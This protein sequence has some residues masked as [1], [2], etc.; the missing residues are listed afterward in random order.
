MWEVQ[1]RIR[2]E[3]EPG[4]SFKLQELISIL[5]K[6]MPRASVEKH[7]T[8][9]RGVA[10]NLFHPDGP[11]NA[12]SKEKYE[13]GQV[14]TWRSFVW[15]SKSLEGAKLSMRGCDE[16]SDRTTMSGTLFVID[17]PKTIG[18]SLKGNWGYD[19]GMF[20][21]VPPHHHGLLH[22]HKKSHA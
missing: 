10:T 2:G 15:V 14:I 6:K 18:S 7:S 11:G 4:N 9:F 13:I 12:I 22:Y 19:I 16:E 17:I 21:N 1:G 5:R 8:L 3:E 20:C